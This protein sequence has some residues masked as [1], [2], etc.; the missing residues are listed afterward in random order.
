MN[1]TEV[2]LFRGVLNWSDSE[3]SRK[4]IEPTRENKRSLI[5]DA[6]YDLR[7]LAMSQYEFAVNVATSGLLTAEEIVP[8]YNTFNGIESSDLKWKLSDKR[9]ECLYPNTLSDELYFEAEIELYPFS[10]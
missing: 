6:I 10:D 9:S 7:F 1:A 8:I 3:C 2:D 5:G 4:D